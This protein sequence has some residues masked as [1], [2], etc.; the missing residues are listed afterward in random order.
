L[1]FIQILSYIVWMPTSTFKFDDRTN[2]L[3]EGLVSRTRSASKSEVLR[4]AIALLYAATQAKEH[5]EEVLFRAKD[6][7]KEREILLW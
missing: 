5:E 7:T 1:T 6:G 2:S 4:K 3:L